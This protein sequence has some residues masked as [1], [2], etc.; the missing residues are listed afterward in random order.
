MRRIFVLSLF[1]IVTTVSS[2]GAWTY[3]D[4]GDTTEAAQNDDFLQ[5][6]ATGTIVPQLPSGALPIIVEGTQYYLANGIWY[7]PVKKRSVQFIVV[8][9]PV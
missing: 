6:L 2:V 1:F 4:F 9:A 3:N 7:M 5:Y 8:R